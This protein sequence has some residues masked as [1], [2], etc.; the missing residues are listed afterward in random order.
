MR[1]NFPGGR[2]QHHSRHDTLENVSVTEVQRLLRA[3][4]PLA[5]DLLSRR[6][7]PF[8]ASLPARLRVEARRIG[9]TLFG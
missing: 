3:V 1:T 6:T 9:Q 7:W 2:W 8:A 4:H 5:V